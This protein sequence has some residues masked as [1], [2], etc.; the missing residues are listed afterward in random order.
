MMA[1]RR[2]RLTLVR[3]LA[4]KTSRQRSCAFGLGL[5]RRGH[6]VLVDATPENLGMIRKIE[7]LL[8]VEDQSHAT[9]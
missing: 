1:V 4:K 3:S 9:Q 2:L 8:A 5:K 7:S 6:S